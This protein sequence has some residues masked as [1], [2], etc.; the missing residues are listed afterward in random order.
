MVKVILK[1]KLE[2]WGRLQAPVWEWVRATAQPKEVSRPAQHDKSPSSSFAPCMVVPAMS[3]AG[4]GG[5]GTVV[6]AHEDIAAW[7]AAGVAASAGIGVG[8]DNV[9]G[10]GGVIDLRCCR[11]ILSGQLQRLCLAG[12]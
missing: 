6:A 2:L 3:S 1:T 9:T 10:E 7:N 4:V 8:P 12:C 11:I 5:E